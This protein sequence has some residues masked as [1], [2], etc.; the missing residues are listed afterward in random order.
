M[1]S[2]PFSTIPIK[3]PH[4]VSR[5]PHDDQPRNPYFHS[6]SSL[7]KNGE[8]KEAL[9]LVT[10]M[11]FRNVRIGPE[12]YGEIL[13]GC[14]YERDFHTGQQ[15]H[16][17]ILKN[18]DFYAKNEYI[19]TKLVIFYAKC[20]ALEIAEVHFSKL[21]VRNVFSWAAIIGVK[22]RMGLVEGAL[23]GFVEMLK[24][25]IFPDNFVVPNVCKACG[26]LQWSGFGRGLHG[27][28][29]KSG[30]DDCV[31]VASSLA[32][33]YGKCGVLDDARKVFDEIP[34][35]N[36]VAWNALMVG[37]VQNGMNE[38]AIRLMCDMR[39]EG[40]EPTRVTVS[41]CLSASA[42]MGG[43]EEGKQSHAVAVVNGLELDNILGTSILNFYCKVGLIDYAEMVFDRMIG[44]DVVT[45]NLLISGYVQQGLVEDAIRM[46]QLMRLEKLKFD[47]VTLS[48]LM[49][50][51]AR[52]QNSKLGKEVQCYCIRHS[53]ESD[54]VLASAV[55]DMYAKCGS[56]VDA[57]KVF[58]STVQKDL[59]L[60]NTL[61]AACAES[62]LSGE[63]LR[64]FYEMQLESVPPNVITWN[65]IILSLFRSGQVDEAKEMF[66]QMQ[67][68]GIVPT[69][70]SWTTMMNGLV[71]NGCSEEAI[72]YLRKMQESGM[73][74]N[75]FS[76]TVAL[77]ACANLASLHF[78][79]SVHGYIIRNRLHSSSVSIETSLV[80]MYA[81]CGDI[82][83]AEKVFRRKLFSELPLYNAMI[84]AY[85]LYG[86]VEE[87]IALY[88]SLE[89][90]GIKPDN[91]TFTNILSACNHA[92]D[93]NQA[94]EIFS[95]MVSK[96]GV[97]PCLE[98]YG[99]MVDLLASAG[100]TEKALRLMEEMPYEPDARMIQSLLAT[101]NKEHKTELVDYLSR[102][103][104][105]SEPDNSG[106]YVTIS[107]AYAG[108]GS[109][110]EVV[111]MR[112]MM[113]A[114]G[115]KKQP[116]C[117]WIRV[118]REEEEEV[119]VFVAN[120]KTHLRN[121]E[122]RRMLALLLYDMRSDSK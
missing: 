51:A 111:K 61:L 113:K 119:Q 92:G 72:H 87:A 63:A 103:L 47:C 11:D 31:F 40:V 6:V 12:I 57:K 43:V 25:E 76:I 60:W 59:I 28:V 5:K 121:N 93:I 77:S 114:K 4:S 36:V 22:C 98:H 67:S 56:I 3:L 23:M 86:N 115:L 7:C 27:Y 109:W 80:D 49:S 39:E 55:V 9:S 89:D 97:K 24:D 112:E 84:S 21:R 52:T 91:I 8:I 34:E 120:D 10:E 48:T 14:V 78:G 1:A 15:I 75:V 122:I 17:R 50:A 69:I 117:S 71:Q 110:D 41:T 58:D 100:E 20:D 68:S 81:K 82:S 45:W 42:N 74:P 66:L 118:K 99:L 37:Y 26:A 33:M 13:Q 102:Q 73:R 85:A 108:E 65:L 107:N 35:R 95:D 62:G 83:K 19:E 79:R 16:A 18:G 94:I 54:I 70:V 64:L 29:A 90:M 105:E 106:N 38:E 44:K 88:G 116:G 30:L 101:C 32:D 46:C 2:L 104:L 96:H 53:F